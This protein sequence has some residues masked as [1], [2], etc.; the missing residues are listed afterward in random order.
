MIT[1][2]EKDLLKRKKTF[3]RKVTWHEIDIDDYL[4]K[5]WRNDLK[6]WSIKTATHKKLIPTSVTSRESKIEAYSICG[7]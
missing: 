5:N 2:N 4:P 3:H 7:G 6:Q 1:Y